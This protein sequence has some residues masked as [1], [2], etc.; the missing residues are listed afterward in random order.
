MEAKLLRDPES[1]PCGHMSGLA[2]RLAIFLK[3]YPNNGTAKKPTGTAAWGLSVLRKRR[4]WRRQRLKRRRKVWREYKCHFR[5]SYLLFWPFGNSQRIQGYFTQTAKS[6]GKIVNGPAKIRSKLS[7]PRL[8]SDLWAI[9]LNPWHK[10]LTQMSLDAIEKYL[11]PGKTAIFFKEKFTFPSFC[12]RYSVSS[13]A[14]QHQ[15]PD[16]W[17]HNGGKQ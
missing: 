8:T 15:R 11:Q 6:G 2:S 7:L 12:L 16:E 9:L 17:R 10:L 14:G 4:I 13:R 5:H 3:N 1:R